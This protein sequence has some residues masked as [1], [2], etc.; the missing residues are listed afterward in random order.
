[1]LFI[2]QEDLYKYKFIRKLTNYIHNTKLV[3]QVT[4]IYRAFSEH[5]KTISEDVGAPNHILR[6]N[7]I[8]YMLV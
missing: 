7:L 2:L 3:K 5:N 1:M 4:Y 8:L 6:E